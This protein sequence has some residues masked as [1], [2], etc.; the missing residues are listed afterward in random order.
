MFL[1]IC[2]V[3]RALSIRKEP[4]ALLMQETSSVLSS[5]SL[6]T[7]GPENYDGKACAILRLLYLDLNLVNIRLQVVIVQALRNGDCF[8]GKRGH[9]G[10]RQKALSPGALLLITEQ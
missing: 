9:E 7:K 6:F 1:S 8:E 10:R 2:H 4:T 3:Q 5:N